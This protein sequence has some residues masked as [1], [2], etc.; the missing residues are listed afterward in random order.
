MVKMLHL[1]KA[2]EFYTTITARIKYHSG[3][4]E[5]Q[6]GLKSVS[7][8]PVSSSTS[9]TTQEILGTKGIFAKMP[10]LFFHQQGLPY[11]QVLK[12][13][14]IKIQRL[15]ATYRTTGYINSI[16][17]TAYKIICTVL[18]EY[19]FSSNTNMKRAFAK[20]YRLIQGTALTK[21]CVHHLRAVFA[22]GFQ[23]V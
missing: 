8:H 5:L 20:I 16:F 7:S 3:T 21:M 12:Y 13:D 23:V 22:H 15:A 9:F 18:H 11:S 1:M 10:L 17:F 2:Y 6:T 14:S 4:V 19:Y